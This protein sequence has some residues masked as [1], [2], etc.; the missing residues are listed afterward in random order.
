MN[1]L[2][3]FWIA[4]R[5]KTL[6]AS[7]SPIC[8]GSCFALKEK[9]FSPFL[10]LFVLL[11]ALCIQIGT[12][13]ANDYFDFLKGADTKD[14]KGPMR[15]MQK[16][17]LSKTHMKRAIA[18]VFCLAFLLSLVPVLKGG[19][20]LGVLGALSIL[21][22]LLY[23]AGPYPIGYIG[24]SDPLVL[25]FFGPFASFGAY[26]VQSESFASLPLIAGIGPGLL[27]LAILTMNNL[28]DI[29]EDRKANKKTLV[30]RF[31]KTFAKAEYF[32]CLIGAFFIPILIWIN[33]SFSLILFLSS[34]FLALFSFGICKNLLSYSELG[35]SFQKTAFLLVPYTF[36]FCLGILL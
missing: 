13:F 20:F 30:V 31:G 10:F 4:A 9:L 22:G 6:I 23:T 5:P 35:S 2:G 29:E 7:I 18:A 26:F 33:G 36:L 16:G 15:V 21:F 24:L 11:F 32:F 28:R 1:S 25:L 19:I 14:R 17:L 3:I 8:I 27:S 12:N 34:F